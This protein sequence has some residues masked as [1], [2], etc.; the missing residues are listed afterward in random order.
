MHG[1]FTTPKVGDQRVNAWGKNKMQV[2][3]ILIW[4]IRIRIQCFCK[5]GFS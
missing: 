1:V 5:L 4:Q 2:R 3:Y